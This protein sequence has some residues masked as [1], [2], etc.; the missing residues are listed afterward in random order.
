MKWNASW[1][2]C[3]ATG[4]PDNFYLYARREFDLADR[5]ERAR[6][7]ITA[8]SLY[9]LW[10]NGEYVGRGPNPSDPSRYY[11]DV[12]DVSGRLRP[13]T[14]CIAV[15]AYCYGPE[16][17]GVLGQ[18]WGRGGLIA[19]LRAPGEEGETLLATDGDWRVLQSPAWKQDV[20]V[21][22]TL[23]GD[24]KEVYDSRL[25]PE[26]WTETGFDDGDWPA[27]EVLG[28]PPVEPYTQLVPREIPFLGGERV[29][30]V[31]AFW[32]S[33]SV[34]YSWRDDWEVY[35]EANLAPG[36]PDARP[37]HMA[38]VC[39]THD[40]FDPS[41]ILDFG[42]DVTGY[43]EIT[44]AD[45]AGGAFDV[46]YGEDLYLTRVD[47]FILRGGRQVLQPYNRRTFR[48]MKLLFR[49]TPEPVQIAEVS[50]KMDT[51][52]VEFA[53]SFECPDPLLNRMWE[54]G[55]HTIRLSMLDHFVD[56]PWRER[57]IYGGDIYPENMI[58]W[59]AF[60]D[61]RLT[62]KTLRQMAAIQY[63]AGALPPY[64]PYSGCDG[65][66]PAWSA[67]WGLTLLDYYR[68]TGDRELLDEL[69]PNLQALLGWAL[70]ELQNGVSLIPEPG[71]RA[72]R[73]QDEPDPFLRWANADRDRYLGWSNFPFCALLRRAGELAGAI[74]D[75]ASA[76]LWSDAGRRMG[77][78]IQKVLVD[79]A[80]GGC[81]SQADSALLLWARIPDESAAAR[82]ADAMFAPDVQPI[83]TPF[84]GYFLLDG[85]YGCGQDQRALDFMRGYWG[86]MLDRGA[87][88]FWEHFG[89]DWPREGVPGRN[90][91]LCHG[92]SAAPTWALPAWVLGVRPLEPGFR[93]FLV[94][95]RPGDLEWA[96]GTVPTPHGPVRVKWICEDAQFR[97]E[98]DVPAGSLA[99]VSVPCRDGAGVALDGSAAP[100][101]AAGRR[102][103][104]EVGE[105]V[106][107]V[108]VR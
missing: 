24:F 87:T 30:P 81:R 76:T 32:E 31:H 41:L 75:T 37:D 15:V 70:G 62:R 65:F 74:G 22:C 89:L 71:A 79:G 10:V 45:S 38:R 19:E 2:W 80:T 93:R 7:M 9:K 54:I 51:Y 73:K 50:M 11:Y 66:Y 90:P 17:H 98:L 13:G 104:L 1:L 44:I 63:D 58:A 95:P 64:G 55:R 6:L 68:L 77:G 72:G 97:L 83:Q 42:R 33:A 94:D 25:E 4:C 8:G 56:C 102:A 26:G 99:E 88:T 103:V 46:L 100:A 23:Y 3:P 21:N 20:P 78:A 67:Y 29:Y 69:W 16:A 105:G 47:T 106:H 43:P 49:E 92:W 53:G 108:V 5:P 57:T 107:T 36:S 60:G 96:S 39:K 48:Y 59:Y 61:G 82:A 35:D 84:H 40:D 86:E 18:N 14:N 52:P 91:S 85:L 28:R 12:H 27:P 101:R 34:T